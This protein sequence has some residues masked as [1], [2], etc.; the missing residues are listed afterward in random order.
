M[1]NLLFMG[2]T[3]LVTAFT[4]SG[5]ATAIRGETEQVKF[6]SN[7][8]GA[9][10]GT[11]LGVECTTPCSAEVKRKLPFDA[12]FTLKGKRKVVKV[13]TKT[14]DEGN[15]AVA[16]NILLGGLIGLAADAESGATLD[17]APNPVHVEF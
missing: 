11:S 13:V 9:K 4:L 6:T 15:A 1:K 10:L 3:V 7:P 8:A 14:S 12:T 5:C 17:H 16:G 2:G